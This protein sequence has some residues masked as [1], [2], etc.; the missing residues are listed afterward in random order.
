MADDPR[1]HALL[2]RLLDVQ[3]LTELL[4]GDVM[5]AVGAIDWRRPSTKRAYI[6]TV[7]ALVEGAQSGMSTY[8]LEGQGAYGWELTNEESSPPC[9]EH[10]PTA[11][12]RRDILSDTA[13]PARFAPASHSL[14][15]G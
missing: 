4:I 6:R 5:E 11:N 2:S 1:P 10:G 12:P 8:L 3:K 14:A 13:P 9:A 7:F 15:T